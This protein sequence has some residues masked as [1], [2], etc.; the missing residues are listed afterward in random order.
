MLLLGC[1]GGDGTD[2]V[3]P[4]TTA[5]PSTAPQG[6]E[7]CTTASVDVLSDQVYLDDT[8]APADLTSLDVHSPVRGPDCPPTPVLVWVHGGGWQTGDRRQQI[9]AKVAWL[10]S[11]GW[12]VV[13]TNHR[14]S[15]EVTYPRHH[16]DVAAAVDWVL[17]RADDLHIDPARVVLAGHSAGAA[18]VAGV[19]T[20]A[21]HLATVGRQRSE[22][23][24][25]IT[26]DTEG[27]DVEAAA[28]DG[29]TVYLVAFG[30]DPDVWADAS[31][32]RNIEAD[33]GIADALVVTRGTP[34]R[35]AMSQRFVDELVAADVPAQLLDAGGLDHAQVNRVVGT[36]G[37][38]VVTPAIGEFLERC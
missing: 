25:M 33:A 29:R 7:A 6:A 38:H 26:L 28:G 16:D 37:D 12:T 3:A 9:E 15:P 31:P 11:L 20:N 18:T 19:A 17:D 22:I 21:R 30:D 8:G 4:E 1:S 24:C 35:R 10:T 32:L 27:Y 36:D 34:A 2:R 5:T 13:S 14:L 23:A